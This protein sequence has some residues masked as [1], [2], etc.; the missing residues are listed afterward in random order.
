M[1][2]GRRFTRETGTGAVR[3]QRPQAIKDV[4]GS[5]TRK[6]Q[7]KQLRQGISGRRITGRTQKSILMDL[8]YGAEPMGFGPT[9]L[10]VIS[11]SIYFI[12]GLPLGWPPFCSLPRAA[13]SINP[14]TLANQYPLFSSIVGCCSGEI[15]SC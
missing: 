5:G 15:N 11:S 8:C 2:P 9:R 10:K 6:K 3:S 13:W 12:L 7:D 14:C 4:F 1:A